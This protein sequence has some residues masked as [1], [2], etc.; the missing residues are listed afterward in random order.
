MSE[1]QKFNE[2][3]SPAAATSSYV[4]TIS[5]CGSAPATGLLAPDT[6]DA[7]RRSMA[8]SDAPLDFRLEVA[9]GKPRMSTPHRVVTS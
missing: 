5:T 9:S 8:E 6:G 4:T 3:N 7:W 2:H 1:S